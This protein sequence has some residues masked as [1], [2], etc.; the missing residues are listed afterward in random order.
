MFVRPTTRNL[1]PVRHMAGTTTARCMGGCGTA[2]EDR[3]VLCDVCWAGL[4]PR[5][6]RAA[7]AWRRTQD[8]N[9]RVAI[10]LDIEAACAL[11]RRRA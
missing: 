1:P 11:A 7:L 8:P 10:V 9:V 6:R 4:S 3:K 2:V 5:R